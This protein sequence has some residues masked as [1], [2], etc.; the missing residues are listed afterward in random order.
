MDIRHKKN[1]E[2]RYMIYFIIGY[3]LIMFIIYVLLSKYCY[4]SVDK[5]KEIRVFTIYS[6]FWIITVP[7]T[8]IYSLFIFIY[9][10]IN[11]EYKS[12]S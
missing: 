8:L 2:G 9:N 7:I 11:N 4:F 3:V 10:L 5:E 12:D 1:L 6:I